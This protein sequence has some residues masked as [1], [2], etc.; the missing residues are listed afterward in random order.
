MGVGEAGE[1]PRRGQGWGGDKWRARWPHAV[2]GQSK[3]LLVDVDGRHSSAPPWLCAWGTLSFIFLD[4]IVGMR[5]PLAGA[6]GILGTEQ[7]LCFL[8]CASQSLCSHVAWCLQILGISTL[9]HMHSVTEWG[10]WAQ[11]RGA[12]HRR[13][14]GGVSVPGHSCLSLSLALSQALEEE[15]CSRAQVRWPWL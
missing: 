15:G 4:L 14:R 12:G 10:C 5:I 9:L 6:V 7:L 3:G 11:V 13:C 1:P 8:L 2:L